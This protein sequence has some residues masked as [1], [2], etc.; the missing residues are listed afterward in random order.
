MVTFLTWQCM[1]DDEQ[2]HTRSVSI[3]WQCVEL[4]KSA[5][6]NYED[7][8]IVLNKN[9]FFQRVLTFYTNYCSGRDLDIKEVVAMML[10]SNKYIFSSHMLMNSNGQMREATAQVHPCIL[11]FI[12]THGEKMTLCDEPARVC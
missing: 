4:W 5:K 11:I 1:T 9:N 10:N 12:H 3:H 2:W 8:K 6:F 7:N